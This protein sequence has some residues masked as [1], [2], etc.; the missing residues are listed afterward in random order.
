VIE[1]VAV[2][3]DDTLWHNETLF[4]LTQERFRALVAPWADVDQEHLDAHLL[5]TEQRNLAHFGY[6]IKG[7]TLSL[8]ETAIELTEG[9]IPATAI[10]TIIDRAREMVAHPVELL[11]GVRETVERLATTHRLVLMTKGDLMD[12]ESKVA[13][14]GLAELFERVEIVSEKDEPT[15]RRIITACG[16][17]PGG[18]LMAGNSLRSDVL[19]VVAVGGNAVHIPYAITWAHEA[20]DV[21]ER[22]GWWTIDDISALPDLIATL[23]GRD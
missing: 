2:D 14:S 20:V 3:A 11:P 18:F 9:R 13:R 8:I 21:V 16:I 4:E 10:Q 7:F 6:G 17:E 23:D 12:Q 5:R 22:D 1:V 15:Y 19:P